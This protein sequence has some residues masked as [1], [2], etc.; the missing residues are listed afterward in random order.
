M[1]ARPE[2]ASAIRTAER[3][4]E[5]FIMA[6]PRGSQIGCQ[7]SPECLSRGKDG[8][9]SKFLAIWARAGKPKL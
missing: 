7:S 3:L 2:I 6:R 8:A 1:R 9:T 5:T 4:F